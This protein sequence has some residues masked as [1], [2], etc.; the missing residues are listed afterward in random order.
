LGKV[1][2]P[3]FAVMGEVNNF[4]LKR[5]RSMHPTRRYTHAG[6]LANAQQTAKN[7]G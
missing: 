2:N 1:N 5:R 4:A 3:V 6:A 7:R